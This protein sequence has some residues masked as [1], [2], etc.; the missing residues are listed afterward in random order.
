MMEKQNTVEKKSAGDA[1]SID[2]LVD[3]GVSRFGSRG[4]PE[5]VGART[6]HDALS[7]KP[8]QAK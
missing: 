1:A 2:E 7:R 5:G 6:A 4:E 3:L 8:K